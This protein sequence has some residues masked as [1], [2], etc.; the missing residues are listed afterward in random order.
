MKPS[1]EISTAAYRCLPVATFEEYTDPRLVAIYDALNPFAADTTFYIG[2]A[3]ELS[4]SSISD[5][6]CGTGLLTCELAH[7]GHEMIGVDPSRAMLAVARH[8]PGGELVR[9]VEGDASQL[10]ESQ[11]DLAIMTGHVAQVIADD[12]TWHKT[13]AAIHRALRPGGRGRSKAAT[14]VH[15]RGKRG[16]PRHPVGRSM[17]L[18][19]AKSRCGTS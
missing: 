8:R 10:D 3:A 5:I 14:R 13:L 11:V 2:L 6:G 12:E 16:R 15:E 17:T 1:S 4:P 18:A 19:W 7:R 9:W